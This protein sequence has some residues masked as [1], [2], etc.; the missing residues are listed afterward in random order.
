MLAVSVY[1]EDSQKENGKEIKELSSFGAQ[2][3]VIF[4]PNFNIRSALFHIHCPCSLNLPNP[5]TRL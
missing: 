2:R 3:Y 4:K 5:H 1:K